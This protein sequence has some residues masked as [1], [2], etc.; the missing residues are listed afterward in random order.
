M[1]SIRLTFAR[2]RHK[3]TNSRSPK[4]T[5]PSPPHVKATSRP[6]RARAWSS[7]TACSPLMRCR[8]SFARASPWL[9]SRRRR[10]RLTCLDRVWG[11]CVGPLHSRGSLP[12]FAKSK[13]RSPFFP[14][15]AQA[16]KRP[17]LRLF[18]A[19]AAL[20]I[21]CP[22]TAVPLPPAPLPTRSALPCATLAMHVF[23]PPP[24]PPTSSG[25]RG[26]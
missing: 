3:S 20:V 19:V 7:S 9:G 22:A 10:I 24:P 11:G 21:H 23:P 13:E 8:G 18:W 14:N 2:S 25:P 4:R 5:S 17:D 15:K 6:R 1:A 26:P 16:T 12:V